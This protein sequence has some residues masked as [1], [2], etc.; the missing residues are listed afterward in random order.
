M[1]ADTPVTDI[2]QPVVIGFCPCFREDFNFRRHSSTGFWGKFGCGYK[3]LHR[4]IGFNNGFT[5][6]TGTN[7]VIQVF[8]FFKLTYGFDIFDNA[9]TTFFTGEA[10]VN[11]GFFIHIAVIVNNLNKFNTMLMA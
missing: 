8:D 9:V 10:L 4:N 2:I 5:A 1:T 7:G 11:A 3:P 6:I